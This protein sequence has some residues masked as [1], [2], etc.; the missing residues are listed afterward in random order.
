M[1]TIAALYV[2]PVGP[3]IG[4][5]GVDAW[6]AERD[7]RQYRGPHPVVAHPPCKRWGR[8]WSGG[9]SVR[10]PRL[11]GDDGG[12]FAAA[13]WAVRTFG[14]VLEHPE[15]SHAWQWFGLSVP[16]RAGGW[17]A[18]DAY[19]GRSC[20]VA[21][22]VYGHR[23]RKLTWLYAVG[24]RFPELDWSHPVG[25]RIDEGFRSN[26]ERAAARAAGVPPIER[27]SEA[28]RIHTPA[29]FRDV[30][31]DMA[32]TVGNGPTQLGLFGGAR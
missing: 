12:C 31:L 2:D 24:V 5:E 6:T 29:P 15:A 8:Y 10:V 11:M 27:L 30:L 13:L 1:K 9:P 14:G 26:Q 25:V 32:R 23:A 4:L 20:C 21:Q 28:E 17:T 16:S 22:G 19:G 7:A 18:V 3:Y